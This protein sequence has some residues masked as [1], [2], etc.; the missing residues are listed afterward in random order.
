MRR[1]YGRSD[2]TMPFGGSR[3]SFVWGALWLPCWFLAGAADL[4][5]RVRQRVLL[6]TWFGSG[7]RW[8]RSRRRRIRP[9]WGTPIRRAPYRRGLG[10]GRSARLRAGYR[11]GVYP[12]WHSA[13]LRHRGGHLFFCPDL[14][15][16]GYEDEET[17]EKRHE[18]DK[19]L[20]GSRTDPRDCIALRLPG[21]Q[22]PGTPYRRGVCN[23][24][25]R[26]ASTTLRRGARHIRNKDPDNHHGRSQDLSV[27][28]L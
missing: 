13:P 10:R 11:A 4:R 18:Q 20:L 5:S 6:L 23:S 22:Q 16:G 21:G 24:R 2:R 3:G 8:Q 17:Q 12:G 14:T 25:Q 1:V 15:S 26:P 27:K 19:A 7:W 9:N 28:F